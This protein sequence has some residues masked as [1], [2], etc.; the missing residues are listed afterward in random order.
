MARALLFVVVGYLLL[1]VQSSLRQLVPAVALVP[2][3]A[4]LL[5]LYLGVTPRQ[6][7][8]VGALV[9]LLLGYFT[10]VLSAA[11]KGLYSL[12]YVLLFFG[13]R[14]AQIR[15]LTRGWIFEVWFSLLAGFLGGVLVTLGRALA[16]PQ[17]G[18]RGIGVAAVQA[19]ATAVTAPVLFF[20]GRR[21]D[22]W[23]SRVPDAHAR[24]SLEVPLK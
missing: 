16:A 7:A 18:V 12:V 13:A 4:L 6:S 23:T 15:L 1:L 3:P 19:L 11:P 9:A 8:W 24:D 5:A 2:D 17:V 22:R 21:L 14:I 20:L 10:D